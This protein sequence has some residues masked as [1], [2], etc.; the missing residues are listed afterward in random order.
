MAPQSRR[1]RG[2]RGRAGEGSEVG[3]RGV[4][5]RW[6]APCAFPPAHRECG[7]GGLGGTR[8]EMSGAPRGVG[9]SREAHGAGVVVRGRW[10]VP[11]W[12]REGRIRRGVVAGGELLPYAPVGHP[13]RSAMR[14]AIEFNGEAV[15][16]QM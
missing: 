13:N 12:R 4:W 3:S 16:D 11:M 6:G 1:V 15:R 9:L 10:E 7:R 14:L 8:N 5:W 2:A